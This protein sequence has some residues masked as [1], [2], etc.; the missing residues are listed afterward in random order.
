MNSADTAPSQPLTGTCCQPRQGPRSP[1]PDQRHPDAGDGLGH[2]ASAQQKGTGSN[3]GYFP[4]YS[5]DYNDCL[6]QGS[7]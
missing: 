7:K 1:V 3:A 6:K 2:A 4:D 5:I